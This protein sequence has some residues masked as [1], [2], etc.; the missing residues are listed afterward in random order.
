MVDKIP[1]EVGGLRGAHGS[2]MKVGAPGDTRELHEGGG[3]PGKLQPGPLPAAMPME[4]E[5]CT[6]PVAG[7]GR[8]PT[9]PCTLS[10]NQKLK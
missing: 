7:L 3:L 8:S 6:S 4:S 9:P 2:C 1:R 10:L 5:G